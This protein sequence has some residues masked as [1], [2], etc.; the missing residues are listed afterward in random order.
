MRS[1]FIA[2]NSW[3]SRVRTSWVSFL[4]ADCFKVNVGVNT[5]DDCVGRCSLLGS[6][7]SGREETIEIFLRY[8]A[9]IFSLFVFFGIASFR[10]WLEAYHSFI[11][12]VNWKEPKKSL[13]KFL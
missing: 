6:A 13:T 10:S 4:G 3:G 7:L 5:E 8:S 1:F 12:L 2:K 9:M 11:S